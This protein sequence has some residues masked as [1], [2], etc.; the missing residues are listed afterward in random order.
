MRPAADLRLRRADA[1]AHARRRHRGRHRD[2]H[3]PP[4]RP[5]RGLQHL[6]RRGA[7]G[8]A[9]SRASAGRHAATIQTISSSSTSRVS[10][11]TY[12]GAGRRSRRPSVYSAGAPASAC[13]TGSRRRPRGCAASAST[14]R[15]SW[16]SVM[17]ANS[18]SAH[19]ASGVRVRHRQR[20]RARR[21]DREAVDRRVVQ[22]RLDP[23][24][25][26][27]GAYAVAVEALIENDGEDVHGRAD[28]R[29]RRPRPRQA[30]RGSRG[31]ARA[32]ARSRRRAATTARW[33]VR[34][35]ARRC[36]S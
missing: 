13:A 10:R 6:G 14:T 29:T 23:A 28:G 3:R 7:D 24:V 2:R 1:D 26:Q 17:P 19:G 18:G 8:R 22:A 4:R 27:G 15:S 36:G 25:V 34:R 32:G 21:V 16:A 31:P 12:S 33:Q 5:E 35:A 20:R 30:A 9:R 11:S